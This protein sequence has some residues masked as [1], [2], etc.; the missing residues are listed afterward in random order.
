MSPNPSSEPS[1]ED[2]DAER[3]P[4][5]QHISAFFEGI[6]WTSRRAERRDALQRA[7]A[8]P[9]SPEHM[10]VSPILHIKQIEV[11]DATHRFASRTAR[12]TR[13]VPLARRRVTPARPRPAR[14]EQDL[15]SAPERVGR[16]QDKEG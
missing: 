4:E 10:R 6:R 1:D 8:T 14:V 7:A 9:Y 16:R 13:G 3:L 11:W 5:A 12:S 15:E 2:R